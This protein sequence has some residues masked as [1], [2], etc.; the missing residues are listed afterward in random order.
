MGVG[1]SALLLSTLAAAQTPCESTAAGTSCGD[2]LISPTWGVIQDLSSG[3]WWATGASG[4]ITVGIGGATY[5]W[6]DREAQ[7]VMALLADQIVDAGF[8]PSADGQWTAEGAPA[9]GLIGDPASGDVAIFALSEA[10]E[11]DAWPWGPL[12]AAPPWVHDDAVAQYALDSD[13]ATADA[14]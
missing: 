13:S 10:A 12:A 2:L 7:A 1:L 5:G 14:R 3:A 4:E 11:A 9:I 6:D 8:T